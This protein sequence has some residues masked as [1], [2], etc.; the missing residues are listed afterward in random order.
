MNWL[1]IIGAVLF[2]IGWKLTF[3]RVGAKVHPPDLC[4]C[5]AEALISYENKPTC[6]DCY[7]LRRKHAPR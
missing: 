3:W 7:R 6:L 1:L 2:F 5:G 4:S